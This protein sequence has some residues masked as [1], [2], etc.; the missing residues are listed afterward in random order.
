DYRGK[1]QDFSRPLN[2]PRAAFRQHR[3]LP[4]RCPETTGTA[5]ARCAKE[6]RQL[7]G[8]CCRVSICDDS[9][10]GLVFSR[11]E[12]LSRRDRQVLFSA[13]NRYRKTWPTL[14]RNTNKTWTEFSITASSPRCLKARSGFW[15][16]PKIP[17]MDRP[18]SLCR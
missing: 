18:N 8:C 11:K 13:P 9:S 1:E 5:A 14:T 7:R 3:P 17:A 4:G 15:N 6:Q 12:P 16:C 2:A 10:R